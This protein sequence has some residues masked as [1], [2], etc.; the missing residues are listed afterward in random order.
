MQVSY[1]DNRFQYICGAAQSTY[2]KRNCYYLT[3]RPIDDAVVQE[4]FGVLQPAQIDALESV[5]SMQAEHQREL[6]HHL[7]QEIQRLEYAAKCARTTVRQRRSGESADRVHA[8][9]EMGR[10]FSGAGAVQ[11]PAVRAEGSR[12]ATGRN[13]SG[14]AGGVR[15]RRSAFARAVGTAS[16][17]RAEGTTSNIGGR[18]QSQ[19][20]HEWRDSN[21]D[22]VAWRRC[23]RAINRRADFLAP[24]HGTRAD[25]RGA[26]PPPWSR[27]EK[28]MSGSPNA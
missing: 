17:R 1:K 15:R 5:N 10:C 26:H 12:S 2:A 6:E 28:T 9:E 16:N 23:H 14:V 25:R 27:R 18:C 11:G 24:Q 19:S 22:R 13:T 4:F 20:R 7:E 3:G 21:Q 8:R